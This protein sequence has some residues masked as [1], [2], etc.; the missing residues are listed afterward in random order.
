MARRRGALPPPCHSPRVRTPH[1]TG[2]RPPVPLVSPVPTSRAARH[3]CITPIPPHS[4]VPTCSML[5]QPVM[6]VDWAAA[7][8]LS[9]GFGT[10]ADPSLGAP[11]HRPHAVPAAATAT[12][13]VLPRAE[14]VLARHYMLLLELAETGALEELLLR[15]LVATPYLTT[16]LQPLVHRLVLQDAAALMG[17]A[18]AWIQQ[19]QAQARASQGAWLAATPHAPPNTPTP[20]TRC[21]RLPSDS[22]S[23]ARPRPPPPFLD[24]SSSSNP[25]VART[26][27][28]SSTDCGR[29][30]R[31][32]WVFG[33]LSPAL[34]VQRDLCVLRVHGQRSA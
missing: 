3:A 25:I 7:G 21:A 15:P 19:L 8:D 18:A 33:W 26:S 17:G 34:R 22:S 20:Q 16:L 5:R 27:R 14:L 9:A 23:L 31:S 24:P 11:I 2:C 13:M 6:R 12:L 4:R 28:P 29:L 10:A 1:G 30:P 32:S